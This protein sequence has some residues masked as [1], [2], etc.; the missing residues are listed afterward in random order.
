MLLFDIIIYRIK[1]KRIIEKRKENYRKINLNNYN[2]KDKISDNR[3][4]ND[5]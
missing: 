3:I 5:N 1:C 2:E 4:K